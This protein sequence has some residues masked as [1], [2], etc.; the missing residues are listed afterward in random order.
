MVGASLK[1]MQNLNSPLP[2]W[3]VGS[4][5]KLAVSGGPMTVNFSGLDCIVESA[6]QIAPCASHFS[7]A[8]SSTV[9]SAFE[10]GVM[11]I[12]HLMLRVSLSPSSRLA[13][14]T[15]PIITVNAWS[16]SVL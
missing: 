6:V 1:A 9:T 4:L 14:A 10:S 13:H 11:L 8:S 7:V 2:L 3:D 15:V 5:S 12:S 16:R